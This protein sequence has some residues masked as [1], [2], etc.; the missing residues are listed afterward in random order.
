[1]TSLGPPSVPND[2]LA[3]V[4]DAQRRFVATIGSLDD[5]FMRRP[6]LLPGW[7]VAHVLTHVARNADSHRRRAEAAADGVVI[8]QYEG[9]L[10]GREQEIQA[11]ASRPAEELIADVAVSGGLLAA[12]WDGLAPSMWTRATRDVRGVERP[13]L[14]LPSRRW[15][16]LEVH[17]VD[18]GAG[19]TYRGWSDDFVSAWLPQLRASLPGRLPTGSA[20]PEP[21]VLDGRDELAWLYGRLHPRGLPI[22]AGWG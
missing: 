6:T 8:D 16:E 4:A 20:P 18:V 9:G 1:V 10:A 12:A 19:V 22:L 11:G 21:G 13:L 2:D 7:T 3:R 14:A 17:V 5:A 15:Q